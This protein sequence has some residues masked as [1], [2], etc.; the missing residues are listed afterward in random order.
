MKSRLPDKNIIECVLCD[1]YA[2]QNECPVVFDT[3]QFVCH[4]CYNTIVECCGSITEMI[5]NKELHKGNI[6][7]FRKI[8]L[9]ANLP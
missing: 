1:K 6:R 5:K 2:Y 4:K 3:D 9:V 7:S 8:I